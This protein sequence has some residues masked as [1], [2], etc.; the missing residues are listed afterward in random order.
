MENI[1]REPCPYRIVDDCGAAFA[2]GATMGTLFH[3]WK[4]YRNSPASK[5][6]MGGIAAMK[7]RAPILGGNFGVWG[8]MFS[9]ID[10]TLIYIRGK[11]DPWSS[12]TS[13]AIT[14]GLLTARLGMGPSLRAAAAGAVILALIEGVIIGLN[15][16][17][18]EQYKPVMPQIPDPSQL[19]PHQQ[20]YHKP[21]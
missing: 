4:G 20:P 19:P 2:M 18:S 5:R 14:S 17:A 9:T 12:I 6:I 1:Q 21:M 8:G 10:C 15:R 3:F 7:I 16:A 13:G 11:E